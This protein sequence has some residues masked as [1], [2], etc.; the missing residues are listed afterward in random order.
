MGGSPAPGKAELDKAGWFVRDFFPDGVAPVSKILFDGAGTGIGID[1]ATSE[2][3]TGIALGSDSSKLTLAT[4]ASRLAQMYSTS[5]LITGGITSLTVSQTMTVTSTGN[6][7]EV[8]QFFLTSNVKTGAW[9]NAVFA[10]IDYSI[11]GLAHGIAGVVCAELDLPG[12]SVARGTYVFFQA[13]VNCPA[14]CA[15]N[16]NPI[17]IIQVNSWGTNK[18]QFDAV[19]YLFDITGVASGAGSFWYD[20]QKAAPAVEEFVRVKT[21]SGVRY[22]ALYDANA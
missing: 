13:E 12:S 15:M 3:T 4:N 17:H 11:N 19:G 14:N 18:T 7:V 16:A 6:H 1:F 21:P 9:A 20:N 8:G 5:S 2:F 10:K 22:L